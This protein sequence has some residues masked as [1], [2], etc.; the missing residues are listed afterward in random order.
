MVTRSLNFTRTVNFLPS[1]EWPGGNLTHSA[2]NFGPVAGFI[3]F[4]APGC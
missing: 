3:R 4:T 1:P 2:V